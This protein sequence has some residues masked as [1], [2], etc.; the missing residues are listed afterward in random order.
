MRRQIA[1]YGYGSPDPVLLAPHQPV[2]T[3]GG[4]VAAQLIRPGGVHLV[5][6]LPERGRDTSWSDLQKLWPA[7]QKPVRLRR[8]H[9][10]FKNGNADRVPKDELAALIEAGKT[11][12]QMAAHFGLANRQHL[13]L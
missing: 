11:S 7:P 9:P 12:T 5:A 1:I 3:C 2:L 8:F 13:D 4:S 6:D 10:T